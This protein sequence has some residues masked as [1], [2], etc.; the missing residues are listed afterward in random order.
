MRI[1]TRLTQIMAWLL[2]QKAVHAGELTARQMASEE[3][4][5]DGQSVCLDD[6]ERHHAGLPDGCCRC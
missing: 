4:R 3:Y 5:L 2:A 1:T 6:D